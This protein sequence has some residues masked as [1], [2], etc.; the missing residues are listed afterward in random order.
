MGAINK[1]SVII[2][3]SC[4]LVSYHLLVQIITKNR[5]GKEEELI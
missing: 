3:Y 2:F 5:H 1:F 4:Y